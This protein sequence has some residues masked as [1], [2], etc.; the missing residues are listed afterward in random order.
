MFDLPIFVVKGG[1]WI[2]D[3]LNHNLIKFTNNRVCVSV[4]NAAQLL[5]ESPA[6]AES[7][8]EFIV[9]NLSS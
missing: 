5:E 7:H 3:F 2:L 9:N 8:D 4:V 6:N 1:N